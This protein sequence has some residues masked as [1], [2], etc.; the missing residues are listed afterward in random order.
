MKLQHILTASTYGLGIAASKTLRTQQTE[1]KDSLFALCQ[2][3]PEYTNNCDKSI[4]PEYGTTFRQTFEFC[5]TKDAFPIGLDV[6]DKSELELVECDGEKKTNTQHYQDSKLLIQS[7]KGLMNDEQFTMNFIDE[8]SGEGESTIFQRE[9]K[10]YGVRVQCL[11]MP[12]TSLDTIT[13]TLDDAYDKAH[14]DNTWKIIGA[15]FGTALSFC[16]FMGIASTCSSKN[17]QSGNNP[18][19]NTQTN[20]GTPYTALPGDAQITTAT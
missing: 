17:S 15:T 13:K 19:A 11:S 20:E 8:C 4:F 12:S 18:N 7:L 5:D 1:E 10:N 6:F 14:P 16:A 2:P 3:P 9:S